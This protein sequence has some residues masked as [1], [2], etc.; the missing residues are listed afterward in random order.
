MP[1]AAGS[2]SSRHEHDDATGFGRPHRV[3][4]G[5]ARGAWMDAIGGGD[6]SGP[7]AL[8]TGGGRGIGRLLARSLSDHGY[9]VGLIARS[10]AELEETVAEIRDV[11]GTAAAVTADVTDE[12]SLGPAVAWLREQLDRSTCW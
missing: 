4:A 10:T 6:R 2:A 3:S 8:V 7:V 1:W 5:E 12:S 9:T 11:G